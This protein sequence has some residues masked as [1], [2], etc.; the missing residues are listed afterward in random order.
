V[1][2]TLAAL[3]ALLGPLTDDDP[4]DPSDVPPPPPD[5]PKPQVSVVENPTE[6]PAAMSPEPVPSEDPTQVLRRHDLDAYSEG[7]ALGEGSVPRHAD[8]AAWV[9]AARLT[10]DDADPNRPAAA[11]QNPPEPPSSRAVPAP[12]DQRPEPPT[13]TR[14][15]HS[16][17]VFAII[18]VL[19]VV[20]GVVILVTTGVVD[21]SAT[22]P[23]GTIGD[24]SVAL[25]PGE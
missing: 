20:I 11:H 6:E 10:A 21:F 15:W 17:L 19:A 3:E 7:V 18:L 24:S 22:A 2:A 23:L 13:P 5:Q 1:H 16:G 4:S 9:A 12:T 14:R 25:A 8:P